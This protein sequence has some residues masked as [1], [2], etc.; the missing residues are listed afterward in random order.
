MHIRPIT[1]LDCVEIMKNENLMFLWNIMFVLTFGCTF[2]TAYIM[3]SSEVLNE[4]EFKST[5][6][7][8]HARPLTTVLDVDFKY[9]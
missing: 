2:A 3:G 8:L 9:L 5:S 6:P 7:A 4:S 1:S